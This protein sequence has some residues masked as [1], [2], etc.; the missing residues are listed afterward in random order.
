M[1]SRLR[2]LFRIGGVGALTPAVLMA[3]TR[4]VLLG[5]L[6]DCARAPSPLMP[7][8]H[9]AIGT[10][11]RGVLRDGAQL[12]ADADGL[13]WLRKD[14]RHWGLPRFTGAIS[15][16]AAKVAGD[17]PGARLYAGDLSTRAGGGP[18]LPHFSHR[19]GVDADLLLYVTTLQGAPV[20][21]PGFVQVGADGLAPDEAHSRWLRFDVRREWL[22]VKCLVED[23]QARTQ[24]IFV[25]DV[26][27][28]LLVDWAI[29]GGEPL[30]TIR[31]AEQ[32]MLQPHP[33]GVHDDHI[34]VRTACSPDEM[35]AGCEPS[36][37]RRDW[38]SYEIPQQ[39][40][41]DEE[42]A[43]ALFRPLDPSFTTQAAVADMH[44]KSLP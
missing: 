10:A 2:C 25:S 12:P 37:P 23:P 34:H 33:G 24:W 28:A 4:L 29:A 5:A 13:R 32:V 21:S 17:R 38:L 39:N 27:Q 26:I 11:N 42:L 6:I 41:S 15:R 35:V 31:R 8:W 19:S 22:L 40:D 9:G 36:G 7:S 1:T 43:L 18:L 44:A 3:V 14:D 30:E 16:C 20:D